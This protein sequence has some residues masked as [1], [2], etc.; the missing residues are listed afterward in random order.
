MA[1]RWAMCYLWFGLLNP[2]L[3]RWAWL[4]CLRRFKHGNQ[5]GG[6]LPLVYLGESHSG[7]AGLVVSSTA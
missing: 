4:H 2:T 5:V 1:A 6:A 3:G 7:L